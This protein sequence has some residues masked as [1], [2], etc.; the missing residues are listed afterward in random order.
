MEVVNA[1]ST[2]ESQE[3]SGITG[4]FNSL[5]SKFKKKESKILKAMSEVTL[6]VK[7]LETSF[8]TAALT[9]ILE[10]LEDEG[11]AEKALA[12]YKKVFGGKLQEVVR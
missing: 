7:K 10:D 12:L 9:T 3:K 5:E 8:Y 2:G 6:K 1:T 4:I 11:E